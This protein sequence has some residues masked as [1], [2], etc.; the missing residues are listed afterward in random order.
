V[1]ADWSV[2]HVERFV[3][4]CGWTIARTLHDYGVDPLIQSYTLA[5]EPENRFVFFQLKATDQITILPKEKA[6]AFRLDRREVR[7][8]LSDTGT[9]TKT[10]SLWSRE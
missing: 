6:V 4:R 10:Q 9:D 5:G 7:A 1:R 3:L 2:N 8:W